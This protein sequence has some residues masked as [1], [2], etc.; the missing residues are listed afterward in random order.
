MKLEGKVAI[1]TAGGRGIGRG[2]ALCLAEEGAD[3]V[4][5]SFHQE[6]TNK[7]ADEIKAMGRKVLTVAGDITETDIMLKTIEDT[8]NTFGKIDI[9]VNNVGGGRMAPEN[10]GSGPLDKEIALW[11]GTYHQNI[12][13]T[14]LMCSAVAP[15]FIKQNSG[16]IVNI[17]SIAGRYPFTGQW[18]AAYGSMKAG[19]I[20]YTQGLANKLGQHN[21]N[22]N[23]VCPG[24]VYT[25]AWERGSKQMVDNTP[26]LKGISPKEWFDLRASGQY[27]QRGPYPALRRAQTEEDMGRAVV[28]LVSEDAKNITG[29]ALNV[30]GGMVMS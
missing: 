26:E 8:I 3:I 10:I 16:K 9:L 30:D 5:N 2:I 19:L 17:A 28:F 12:R 7:V 22:A 4:V 29:Q 14:V 23:C 18:P 24:I 25:A 6:T 21:I 1:V 27:P 15:Y 20:R 13:A 11:N